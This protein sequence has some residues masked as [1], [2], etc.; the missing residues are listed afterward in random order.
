MEL[1]SIELYQSSEKEEENC[2]FVCFLPR[3]KEKLGTITL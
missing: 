1:D 3:K 2:C